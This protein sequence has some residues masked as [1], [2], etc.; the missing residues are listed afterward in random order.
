MHWPKI[1]NRQKNSLVTTLAMVFIITPT[2]K[3]IKAPIREFQSQVLALVIL[4]VSEPALIYITPLI[5]IAIIAPITAT[6]VKKEPTMAIRLPSSAKVRPR[7]ATGGGGI[8][9]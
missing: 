1:L 4:V 8:T 7:P 3:T 5:I 9:I 6:L 2:P